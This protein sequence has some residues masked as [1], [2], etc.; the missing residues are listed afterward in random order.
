MPTPHNTGGILAIQTTYEDMD[1]TRGK[2]YWRS[3]RKVEGH[4]VVV[5]IEGDQMNLYHPDPAACKGSRIY[6]RINDGNE[7]FQVTRKNYPGRKGTFPTTQDANI[8]DDRVTMEIQLLGESQNIA[9]THRAIMRLIERLPA[10]GSHNELTCPIIYN[11]GMDY[12]RGGGHW[13]SKEMN[14]VVAYIGRVNG[15]PL[16][17]YH[18]NNDDLNGACNGVSPFVRILSRA[19]CNQVL[20]E[21]CRDFRSAVEGQE[22][23][24]VKLHVY[25]EG[26][27]RATMEL[28]EP[29][30]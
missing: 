27:F 13:R 14:G 21:A 9:D 1:S 12:T 20:G 28:I 15:G 29:S 26:K 19:E 16:K 23:D 11:T 17:L 24:Q 2:G 7:Y 5:S 8:K 4:R 30:D 18:H 6:V 22:D 25:N 10:L 3:E